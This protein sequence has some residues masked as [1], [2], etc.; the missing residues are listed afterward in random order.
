MANHKS[1]IKSYKVVHGASYI[2]L[3]VIGASMVVPLVWMVLTSLKRPTDYLLDPKELWPRL[4]WRLEKTDIERW[5]VFCRSLITQ[6]ESAEPS[7]GRRVWELIGTEMHKTFLDVSKRKP[8]PPRGDKPRVDQIILDSEYRKMVVALHEVFT[9]RE[10]YNER[11]FAAVD[12]PEG[13]KQVLADPDADVDRLAL[14]NR[15]IFDASYPQFVS[16]AHRLQWENYKY[17]VVDTNFGRSLLNSAFMT[18]AVTFGSVFT[19]SLAAFAF[20]R[21]NWVGR[22]KVFLA[23]L[24]TMMIPSAVT[25]IPTFVL[26]RILGWVNTYWGLIV[27]GMFTAWGTFMLRQFFMSIPRDLE[28]AALLDGCSIWGIYRHVVLPLSKPAV[29]ALTILTFMGVWREFMWPLIITNTP[30]MHTL[31]VALAGFSDR[32]G[33][34]WQLMMAGSVIM[35]LPMLVV[36]IFG[37]RYFV[38][39]IKLG[40]LK[41]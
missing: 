24:A 5:P 26:M 37:Q 17:V 29:A 28:D 41:G 23:Y 22:D 33:I 34:K 20:A 19:S 4:P 9:R 32:Y 15:M 31:A 10:L 40:A 39:G 25:L 2:V 12:V 3:S 30:D 38:E 6:G 1:T 16:P 21:L 7:P 8:S 11:D 18:F 27:P 36:F 35:V 13:S 14:A